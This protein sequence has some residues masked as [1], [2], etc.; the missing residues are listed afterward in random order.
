M[1][2]IPVPA[3]YS[4]KVEQREEDMAVIQA[5]RGD[6]KTGGLKESLAKFT[7]HHQEESGQ[8]LNISGIDTVDERGNVNVPVDKDD[9]RAP[10]KHQAFPVMVYHAERK[11]AVGVCEP[12]EAV[13]QDKEELDMLLKRGYR[14]EP[15]PRP[16]AHL[17]D[18][19]QEK[20]A[21]QQELKEKD[22]E[23]ARLRDVSAK[24]LERMEALEAAA[25]D[26]K[27]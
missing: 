18:P 14:A 21:L 13:A 16:V 10:Y 24:L 8:L 5:Y 11:P 15:Y 12:G 19:R 17:E 23:L 25:T 1:R 6:M 7:R 20:A 4:R 9:P 27:K 22:G 2:I 26:P 3:P